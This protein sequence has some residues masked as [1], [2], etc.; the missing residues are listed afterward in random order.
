MKWL[1]VMTALVL[2]FS[3]N[4]IAEAGD[5]CCKP[6]GCGSSACGSYLLICKGDA[7]LEPVKKTCWDVECKPICIPP[8]RFPWQKN[9]CGDGCG[10]DCGADDCGAESCTDSGCSEKSSWC[11][12][13]CGLGECRIRYVK[14]M[15]KVEYEC[16]QKCVYSW[17]VENL[18]RVGCCKP[19]CW[20][21][22]ACTGSVAQPMDENA[23]PPAPGTAEVE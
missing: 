7:K 1:G 4:A 2:A 15:K 17:K 22:G 3:V 13:L 11:D 18:G 9:G 23:V 14:K 20:S 6:S 21:D 10:D 12:G 8:V 19:A 16:G 5:G